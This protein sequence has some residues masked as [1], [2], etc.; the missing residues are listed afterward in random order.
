MLSLFISEQVHTSNKTRILFFTWKLLTLSQAL[1][2]QPTFP[3]VPSLEDPASIVEL[4][5]DP[6]PTCSARAGIVD[7]QEFPGS[8]DH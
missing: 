8:L 7:R 4:P 2:Q 1:L 3:L 6:N 5:V